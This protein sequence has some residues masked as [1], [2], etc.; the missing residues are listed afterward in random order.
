M[1]RH[2]AP[3]VSRFEPFQT[4]TDQYGLV[5]VKPLEKIIDGTFPEPSDRLDASLYPNNHHLYWP[6]RWYETSHD[7]P[8]AVQSARTAFRNHPLNQ[9]RI[10]HGAHQR[11]H[12]VTI[13]PPMPEDDVMYLRLK[14]MQFG[15]A[16]FIASRYVIRLDRE[17]RRLRGE[18]PSQGERGM[19]ESRRKGIYRNLKTYEESIEELA[20]VPPE[21]HIVSVDPQQSLRTVATRLGL[22]FVGSVVNDR[23]RSDLAV[24]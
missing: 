2:K 16:A 10:G 21:L 14:Y 19:A 24:V 20:A 13:P 22:L 9:L 6:A 5:R 11:L 7:Y 1:N 23:Y 17:L 4:P 15:R 3:P 12:D 8:S 18:L